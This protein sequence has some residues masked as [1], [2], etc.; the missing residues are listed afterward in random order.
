MYLLTNYLYKL[1]EFIIFLYFITFPILIYKHKRLKELFKNFNIKIMLII[2]LLVYKF[3]I[4]I[5][6]LFYL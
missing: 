5:Y 3:D 4:N 1:P 2:I 6:Q